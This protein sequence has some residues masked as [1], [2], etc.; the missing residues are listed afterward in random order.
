[1]ISPHST[2]NP[3]RW[4]D[5]DAAQTSKK[6][7]FMGLLAELCNTIDQPEYEFGR[8]R[9]P[10]SDMLFVS[11]YKVYTG[12]SS[13]RF[14]SDVVDACRKGYIDAMPSYASVNLYMANPE[15]TPLIKGLVELSATPLTA[16][17]SNFAADATG[18]STSRFDRWYSAKWGRE[19][20]HRRYKKAHMMCGVR[21]HVVTAI[22]VTEGFVHDSPLLPALV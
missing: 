22:E 7:V 10:L 4:H 8:P 3:R 5:Y 6:P 11:A 2:T 21:T 9:L 18:F 20:S 16:V 12:F 17:E 14:S 19:K 1:M 15:L 13:R